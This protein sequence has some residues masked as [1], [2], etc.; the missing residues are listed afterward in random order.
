MTT[1]RILCVDSDGNECEATAERL[2]SDLAELEPTVETAASVSAAESTLSADLDAIVTEYELSD[3]TGIDLLNIANDVCPDAGVV[4]YTDI[5]PDTIDTS[6][7]RNTVTEYVGKGSVFGGDR[8]TK[9]VGTTVESRTQAS[10][11]L[12]QSES[13]RVAALQSYDLDAPGLSEALTR[14][15]DLAA[16]HFDVDIASINII[17]E[18]SQEFLACYGETE[19]WEAMDRED[20]ICTFTILEDDE[21][22]TVPDVAEDSRFESRSDDLGE[23]GIRSYMGANLVTSAGLV[24]G[25]LCIYDDRPQEFSAAD[26]AYLKDLAALAMELVELYNQVTADGEDQ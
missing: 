13:E 6:A 18:H 26:E 2:R 23:L 12:P 22:M 19:E 15:T 10:Y 7:L 17:N 3:R 9:L 5:D 21:V 16:E 25:P 11:P 20:S 1:P 8:L 4:L 14:V 24:I